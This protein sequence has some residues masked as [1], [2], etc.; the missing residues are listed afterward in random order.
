MYSY[1]S[2]TGHPVGRGN[3]VMGAPFYPHY[4]PMVP[5]RGNV[6]PSFPFLHFYLNGYDSVIVTRFLSYVILSLALIIYSQSFQYSSEP[7]NAWYPR[8]HVGYHARGGFKVSPPPLTRFTEDFDFEAMNQKFNKEEVWDQ[9]SKSKATETEDK[10]GD[11]KDDESSDKQD[12]A[13][14]EL[15]KLDQPVYC[16]DD[17]FD[18]IS[19]RSLETDSGKGKM[20]V[21]ERRKLDFET[22]GEMPKRRHDRGSQGYYR[23]RGSGNAGGGRGRGGYGGNRAT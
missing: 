12:E 7:N 3:M 4:L 19:C 13:E 11:D 14:D 9:L 21:S 2:Y 10:E 17:F 8:P 20:N 6:V 22:F 15:P 16:K 23:G 18:S 1:Q 5:V